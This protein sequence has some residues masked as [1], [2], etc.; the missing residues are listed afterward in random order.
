MTKVRV[1]VAGLMLTVGLLGLA[2]TIAHAQKNRDLITR[3]DIDNSAL[4]DQDIY[5]VIRSLRPHFFA[6]PRGVRSMGNSVSKFGLWVDGIHE[7]DVGT[8]RNILASTVLEVRYLDPSRAENEYGTAAS[9]GAVIVKRIKDMPPAA[10][11]PRDTTKPPQ[12]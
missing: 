5:A 1:G 9:G 3:E 10:P 11:P 8:L 7:S 2:P 4:K 6:T 12:S